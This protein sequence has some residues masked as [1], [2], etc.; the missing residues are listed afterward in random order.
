MNFLTFFQLALFLCFSSGDIAPGPGQGCPL[1]N[2]EMA[3]K[4]ESIKQKIQIAAWEYEASRQEY[5]RLL[6]Y[7]YQCVLRT[8]EQKR[9]LRE[10]QFKAM[11][12]MK[13]K[14]EKYLKILHENRDVYC[15]FGFGKNTVQADIYDET[16]NDYDYID[17]YYRPESRQENSG[18]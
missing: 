15:P 5:G 7:N 9:D 4:L 12:D 14:K 16:Y 18:Y 8:E 3:D 10:R 2:K 13:M 17:E 1:T 11:T 6:T